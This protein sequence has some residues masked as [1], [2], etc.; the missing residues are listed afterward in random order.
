MLGGLL[1]DDVRDGALLVDTLEV[2]FA[3]SASTS[4]TATRLHCHRNTVLHRLGRVQELTGRSPSNP[5]QAAELHVAIL[6][7]RLGGH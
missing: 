1:A 3:T 4:E 6:A 2:W 7:L 5:A